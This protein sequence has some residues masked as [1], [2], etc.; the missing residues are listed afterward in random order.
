M[1]GLTVNRLVDGAKAELVRRPVDEAAL[2]AAAGE[3]HREAVGVV[4]ASIDP[5]IT[6]ERGQLDR[7]G[8]AK[9]PPQMTKVSS[10]MPRC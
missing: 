5:G 1:D 9:L 3:P 7:G 10:S 8:A 2:D 4:V 6:A